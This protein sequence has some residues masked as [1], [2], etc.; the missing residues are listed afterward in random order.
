MLLGAGRAHAAACGSYD[1]C[2]ARQ[3]QAVERGDFAAAQAAAEAALRFQQNPVLY[4]NLGSFH[5]KQGHKAEALEYYL[6]YQTS[7]DTSLTEEQRDG[8][9]RRIARLQQELPPAP[10]PKQEPQAIPAPLP[11]PPPPPPPVTPARTL[12]AAGIGVGVGGLVLT[13]AGAALLALDKTRGAADANGAP[14][15]TDNP[16]R[17]CDYLYRTQAPG[18]ALAAV[19]RAALG[20]GIVLFAIDA[21]RHRG[22]TRLTLRVGSPPR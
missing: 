12:R 9:A 4:V 22:E 21:R 2:V 10:A 20:G 1:E 14:C 17:D 16:V 7:G 18:I 6:R 5:E 13:A 11:P 15:A 19:R 8:G 3:D